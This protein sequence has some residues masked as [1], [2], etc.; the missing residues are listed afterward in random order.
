MN[1][2]DVSKLLNLIHALSPAFTVVPTTKDGGPGTGDTWAELLADIPAADAAQAVRAHFATGGPWIGVAD[3]RRRVLAARGLLPPAVEE[4]YAQARR[5]NAWLDRRVGPEPAIHPAA[6]AAGREIGWSTF[7][8]LEGYAHKRF[9]ESYNPISVRDAEKA[10]TTALP[11][12]VAAVT[13]PKALPAGSGVEPA[14][15]EAQARAPIDR[16]GLA[17]VRAMLA[18]SGFGRPVPTADGA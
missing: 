2:A 17:K 4:A 8:G 14:E 12:L 3:I 16:E 10:L 6:M 5:M 11:V 15:R 13:A 1:R 18:R 7:D 9:A